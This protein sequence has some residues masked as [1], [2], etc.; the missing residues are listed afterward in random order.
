MFY[1][2]AELSDTS[3]PTSAFE[4]GIS[5]AASSHAKRA[6]D[7]SFALAALLILLP[8][9]LL[10]AFL[11]AIETRGQVLFTQQRGGLCGRPFRIYKFRTMRVS[12]DGAEV[13]QVTQ[14][15][16]RVTRL[17][18]F[19]RRTSLDEL[20]QL[21]NVL[22]GD[23]SLVGPR[24][25]ALSHDRAFAAAVPAYVRRTTARPGVTG[26]AQISGCRGEIKCQEDLAR[27]VGWDIEYI[28]SWSIDLDFKIIFLTC[29]KVFVDKQAF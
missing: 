13:R 19:L 7:V 5:G 12:E 23:M 15:D 21:I 6:M 17:G 2:R 22:T 24:P 28:N 8:G 18:V 26:L 11:V 25:H 3:L 14:D 29:A 9:L 10:I 16:P 27:R 20:P 4:Q 1:E